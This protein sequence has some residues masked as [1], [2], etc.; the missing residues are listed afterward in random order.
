MTTIRKSRWRLQHHVALMVSAILGVCVGLGASV[1]AARDGQTS[2]ERLP[3]EDLRL[4]TEVVNRVKTAYVE[5]I[6]DAIA[7]HQRLMGVAP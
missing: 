4:F 5:E 6:D 7:H 1:Y 2:A 3:L